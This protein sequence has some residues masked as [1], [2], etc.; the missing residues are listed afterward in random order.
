LIRSD[1]DPLLFDVTTIPTLD[2]NF[3]DNAAAAE[4][5][6]SKLQQR[7]D[8]TKY[9]DDVRVEIALSQL[10]NSEM[11][12][13]KEFASKAPGRIMGFD[14]KG[15]RATISD[16]AIG[17]LVDKQII[18]SVGQFDG[19]FTGYSLTPLG[20]H[21]AKTLSLRWPTFAGVAP[22]SDPPTDKSI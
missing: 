5:L 10:T 8:E 18:K 21:A 20:Y 13:L 22:P 2:I 16:P 19:G 6:V 3:V 14:S 1:K 9:Y 7:L 15:L 4:L 17:R 11:K 12:M